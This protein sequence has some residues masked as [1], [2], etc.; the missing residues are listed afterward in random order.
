MEPL[1]RTEPLDPGRPSAPRLDAAP[2]VEA[3]PQNSSM[4]LANWNRVA[5]P[6]NGDRERGRPVQR[7]APRGHSFWI[8]AGGSG[9]DGAR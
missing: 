8:Y 2:S 6:W 4:K 7:F 1:T 5:R 9:G 3:T